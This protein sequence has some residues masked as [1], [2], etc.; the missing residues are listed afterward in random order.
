M[1]TERDGAEGGNPRPRIN[2]ATHTEGHAE[3]TAPRTET[4][5]VLSPGVDPI[6][7]AE[8][9]AR[10]RGCTCRATYLHRGLTHVEVLHRD[11]CALTRRAATE[12]AFHSLADR[13]L[14]EGRAVTDTIDGRAVIAVPDVVIL[15]AAA[16]GLDAPPTVTIRRDDGRAIYL[17]RAPERSR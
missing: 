4:A 17:F 6:V 5:Y 15:E 14:A 11:G 9:R 3:P 10:A 8:R 13:A 7:D 2:P 12:A 16:N 1:S